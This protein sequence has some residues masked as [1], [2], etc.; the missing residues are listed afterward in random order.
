M[1]EQRKI[2]LKCC[3]LCGESATLIKMSCGEYKITCLGAC[4][5]MVAAPTAQQAEF[6]WN[7]R[8]ASNERTEYVEIEGEWRLKNE[9]QT[10]R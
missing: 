7:R 8:M 10:R 3:P 1:T 6:F 5:I 4:S 9:I 2:S